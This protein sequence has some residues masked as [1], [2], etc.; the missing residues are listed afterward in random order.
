VSEPVLGIITPIR[1]EYTYTTGRARSR[2]LRAL[3]Q[4]RIIGERCSGCGHVYV[5]PNGAC[6]TCGRPTEEQVEL[7]PTGTVTMF[8]IVNLPFYGQQIQPP[9][10]C[11]SIRLDGADSTL[12]HLIQEIPADRV[13]TG[14]RVEA[15]WD[16]GDL[17][18]TMESILYFRPI[19]AAF[20]GS[21]S[22]GHA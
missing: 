8:C 14:M 22:D 3:A 5:P 1:L 12:F 17:E 4:R 2:F 16:E 13:A 19:A 18:P 7:P 10:V 6:P 11:A 9:Y 21:G 15:V 20:G